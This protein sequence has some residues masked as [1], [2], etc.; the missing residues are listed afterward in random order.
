M[1]PI[2]FVFSTGRTSTQNIA[3]LAKRSYPKASVEHEGLGP[4][5]HSRRV[6]RNPEKFHQVLGAQ[7]QIQRKLIGIEDGMAQGRSYLDAGWPA[8]GWLPYLSDR[9][10]ENFRFAHLVRN[11]FHT[12]A[13]LTTHGLFSQPTKVGRRFQRLSMIHAKDANT[14]H[15]SLQAYAAGF[16]PF[17]RNLFHWLELNQFLIEHHDRDGF[18]G[19]FRFE[20]LYTPHKHQITRMLPKLLGDAD[21][22]FK[23][24][25]VDQVQKKLPVEIGTA[26]PALS[27]AV[28]ALAERLGYST[29][30]LTTAQDPDALNRTYA[31]A[32]H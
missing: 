3:A 23:A 30:E 29:E 21:I 2:A 28:M 6:F 19:L 20:D 11:P 7:V 17:D 27:D 14:H 15:R 22:D 9:F 24:K 1:P 8:F 25:P 32:R 5:Y 26:H 16:S 12:A 10:G 13:S 4:Y 31:V 18:V